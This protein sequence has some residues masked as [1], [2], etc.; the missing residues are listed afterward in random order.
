MRKNNFS[1]NYLF[2]EM[3]DRQKAT[4]IGKKTTDEKI[5][6]GDS[7][8]YFKNEKKESNSY[9]IFLDEYT[10]L[11]SN[12][13][14]YYICRIDKII[15]LF[16]DFLYYDGKLFIKSNVSMFDYLRVC[17]LFF[18]FL[19]ENYYRY[20]SKSIKEKYNNM[21]LEEY[22]RDIEELYNL[23]Y[24]PINSGYH[25][26]KEYLLDRPI[27]DE[28]T[29]EEMEEQITA[30]ENLK[31]KTIY[32]MNPFDK[33]LVEDLIQIY[34]IIKNIKTNIKI[35]INEI[36][37][38]IVDK[39]IEYDMKEEAFEF[40]FHAPHTLNE[41]FMSNIYDT[42]GARLIYNLLQDKIIK[43]E[44]WNI[45]TNYYYNK[46]LN[47][48][49]ESKN[50]NIN[51]VYKKYNNINFCEL[52][53][54]HKKIKIFADLEKDLFQWLNILGT[55]DDFFSFDDFLCFPI[56]FDLF[57]E[58]S[59]NFKGEDEGE[60]KE[61]EEYEERLK[62][63]YIKEIEE[64][65][66][67]EEKKYQDIELSYIKD[68]IYSNES[69][70]IN[71]EY[72]DIDDA[73]DKYVSSFSND[74]QIDEEEEGLYKTTS[75]N[76]DTSDYLYSHKTSDYNTENHLR[77]IYQEMQGFFENIYQEIKFFKHYRDRFL[78][79]KDL[80][81][82]LKESQEIY[83]EYELIDISNYFDKLNIEKNNKNYNKEF[84]AKYLIEDFEKLNIINSEEK[85][86]RLLSYKKVR[87][88]ILTASNLW[89]VF[90]TTQDMRNNK[91]G[92][93]YTFFVGGYFKAIELLLYIKIKESYKSLK[94]KGVNLLPIYNVKG[95]KVDILN[96]NDIT[97]GEMIKYIKREKRI[98][99]KSNNVLL[100]EKIKNWTINVRN[101]H[102]HKDIISKKVML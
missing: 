62:E 11:N 95:A 31:E 73:Y 77:L 1:I 68:K 82:L 8:L 91:D 35:N 54:L 80:S 99:K 5:L 64:N 45:K 9:T 28:N 65:I 19:M 94:E 41:W 40:L 22:N 84:A 20:Y 48:I 98:V 63:E 44:H 38:F 96:N 3:V 79:T 36:E 93:D 21:T 72:Y 58:Y 33:A 29:L 76:H 34:F 30:Y 13:R 32:F 50:K 92:Q 101:A 57:N 61:I 85:V 70:D 53:D 69:F 66:Y 27:D 71:N 97:L 102:F 86:E 42:N 2:D 46:I 25:S 88:A 74:F 43:F 17:L 59:K 83:E 12:E 6:E 51:K 78:S 49:K 52:K 15:N 60:Y 87:N 90:E 55:F 10:N 7:L 23:L 67:Y 39:C 81:K 18:D 24:N 89:Y 75:K 26:Y 100:S 47:L 16:S 14:G 56:F 4:M 37:Y